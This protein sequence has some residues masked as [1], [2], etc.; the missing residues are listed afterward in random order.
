MLSFEEF[1]EKKSKKDWIKDATK[2]NK[3][4]LRKALGKKDDEEITKSDI[5]SEISKLRKKDKDKSKKGI[6]GLSKKDLKHYRRLNLAKTLAKMESVSLSNKEIILNLSFEDQTD[7]KVDT[8]SFE[9][10]TVDNEQ[11]PMFD[12]SGTI[13][14]EADGEYSVEW[15]LNIP[16]DWKTAE[17]YIKKEFSDIL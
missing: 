2:N 6:Q 11:A 15:D 8:Y 9:F 12:Y 13:T 17:E 7:I 3:G 1:N 10:E 4:A 5:N 16:E 14:K